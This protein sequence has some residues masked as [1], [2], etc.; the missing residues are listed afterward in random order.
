MNYLT[1]LLPFSLQK[2]P[3]H[4][5]ITFSEFINIEKGRKGVRQEFLLTK[6]VIA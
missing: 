4:F 6:S 3:D 2:H 5:K 1:P